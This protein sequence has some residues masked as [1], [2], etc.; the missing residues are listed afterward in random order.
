MLEINCNNCRNL[1]TNMD[2][3]REC[4][5]Y[6][7]DCEEATKA[8][9]RD[10]FKNATVQ[11]DRVDQDKEDYFRALFYCPMCGAFLAS[12]NYGRAWTDNGLSDDKRVDCQ[13]CG[14]MIDWSGVVHPTEEG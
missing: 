8:C 3:T 10:G 9:I 13:T 2:G 6:G 11:P 14:Q 4:R 7:P 12:Y 5:M 1:D